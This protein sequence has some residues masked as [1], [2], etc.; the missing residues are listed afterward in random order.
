MRSVAD[1][2]P[3]RELGWAPHISLQ[4]GLARTIQAAGA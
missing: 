3:L 4:D 1:T 2:R